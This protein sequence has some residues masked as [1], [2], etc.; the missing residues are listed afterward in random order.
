MPLFFFNDVWRGCASQRGNGGSRKR[1]GSDH[2]QHARGGAKADQ[3]W[4][5]MLARGATCW[6][7]VL[8]TRGQGPSIAATCTTK[9]RP[10]REQQSGQSRPGERHSWAAQ[11]EGTIGRK[12]GPRSRPE[13]GDD[14]QFW[15]EDG[16]ENPHHCL[17]RWPVRLSRVQNQIK[18]ARLAGQKSC[19]FPKNFC[20]SPEGGKMPLRQG[21]LR[22][23]T[24]KVNKK[25]IVR[26]SKNF[27]SRAIHK[28]SS[29][30]SSPGSSSR[31]QTLNKRSRSQP[32]PLTHTTRS[33]QQHHARKLVQHI[34][35]PLTR[36]S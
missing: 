23:P 13:G 11:A 28:G 3:G 22:G 36:R 2:A 27:A 10:R 24:R 18:R 35:I 16:E 12:E 7:R 32:P 1:R 21:L 31:H 26:R 8:F 34:S 29:L 15:R 17:L 30:N 25:E 6:R 4:E 9:K 20:G 5:S 14:G 33:N 19:R